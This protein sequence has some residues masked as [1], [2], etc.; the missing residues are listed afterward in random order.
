MRR[1]FLAFVVVLCSAGV[2]AAQ[3]GIYQSGIVYAGPWR[4][5]PFGWYQAYDSGY[6][7]A[8]PYPYYGGGIERELRLQRWAIEDAAWARRWDRSTIGP[9]RDT[10]IRIPRR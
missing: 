6:A 1:V 8:A 4:F 5:G 7:Y 10:P 2:A 3:G 9:M